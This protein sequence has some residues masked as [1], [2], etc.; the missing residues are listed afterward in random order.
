MSG[1]T[2]EP[3]LVTAVKA[4]LAKIV[5]IENSSSFESVFTIAQVHGAPYRGETWSPEVR[6]VEAALAKVDVK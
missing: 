1:H 2:A 5:L 3:D 6:A 4:L